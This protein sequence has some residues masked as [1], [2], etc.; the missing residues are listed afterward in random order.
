MMDV[1]TERVTLLD[2]SSIPRLG[3]GVYKV[4]ND[5]VQG[6][7]EHALSVGYRLIDTAAMYDNEEGVG[8]AI[9]RSD[10][11]RSEIQIA[12]KFWMDDLGYDNTLAA[13]KS[14]LHR[15]NLEYLDLYLIHWPA[16]ARG[17]F[18]ESWRAMQQLKADGL[19]RSIGV[20]NF[21]T[22][23]IDAIVADSGE[24]PVLNQVELHP[25]LTQEPLRE[26]HQKAGILTQAWSPLARGQI[27]QEPALID[28]ACE[29]GVSV[30]QLVVRWHLDNDVAVIPK[31]NSTARITQ[32][33][34]V[35]GFTLSQEHRSMISALNKNYRTGVDPNDRN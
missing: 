16:P 17:L 8:R 9:A 35:F 7:V 32:N 21:H 25:W 3:L 26:Y 12:T 33:A 6:L 34:D 27:L 30:A 22:E 28:L 13:A 23:H 31:S 15:M 18:V 11:P 1:T 2:G 10:V 4:D 24:A 20:C 14:S 19:V 5:T 29:H